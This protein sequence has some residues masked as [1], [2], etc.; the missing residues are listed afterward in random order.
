M[1]NKFFGKNISPD[2][3]Y[4]THAVLNNGTFACGKSKQ[5]VNGKC[6]SFDYDPLMRVPRTVTLRG[7]YTAEDFKL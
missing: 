6:R 7:T 5:L 2:C 1:K 3:S 4:C